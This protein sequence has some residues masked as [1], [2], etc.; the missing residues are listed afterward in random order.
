MTIRIAQPSLD[1]Y[2]LFR[3][4]N[5]LAATRRHLENPA[6]INLYRID[7][8]DELEP[9]RIKP[10]SV[11]IAEF[12]GTDVS[13]QSFW[14]MIWQLTMCHI[15]VVVAGNERDYQM[16]SHSVLVGAACMV[17]SDEDCD[18]VARL[19][20]RAK[21]LQNPEFVDWKEDIWQQLPWRRF[22][23]ADPV[24]KTST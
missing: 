14:G 23:V 6:G 11:V 24:P 15:H 7:C 18:K 9:G 16:M 3:R 13:T 21:L 10:G 12:P 20:E 4:R 2:F 17:T 5:W 22:A 8:V 19:I 1:C